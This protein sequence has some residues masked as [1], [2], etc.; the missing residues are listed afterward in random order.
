MAAKNKKK[1]PEQ[2]REERISLM[3]QT[4]NKGDY[5]GSNKD[6]M[7]W[8]GGR[9]M[10][11]IERFSS[12]DPE[13]DQAL[14]GG[15]PKGRFIEVYGPE[16]G[17]KSTLCLHAVAEHQKAYPEE[18]IVF[19]DTE[20]SF[21]EE[22]AIALGVD[23]RWLIFHQ[24][25]SGTQ[26]LNILKSVIQ[27]GA[28]LIIV[29]SVAALTTKSDIEVSVIEDVDGRGRKAKGNRILDEPDSGEDRCDAR[30]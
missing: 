4:I 19:I 14:G 3:C 21:D 18:D 30:G 2:L 27:M 17:G 25:D 10:Q 29:D 28:K 26:A 1:T 5:G 7:T 16:S 6:A 23:T 20:Y 12:G 11:S 8:L 15:W 9:P 13:L 24:P 22:Y